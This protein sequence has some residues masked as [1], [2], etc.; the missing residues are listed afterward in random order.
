MFALELR[1]VLSVA[2]VACAL[3][4]CSSS[5][6]ASSNSP[7]SG[8]APASAGATSPIADA[9]LAA[10][11]QAR[12]SVMPAPST[13]ISALSWSNEIATSAQAWADGCM[14]KHSG[15]KYGENIFASAGANT[16]PQGVV[17]SWVAEVKD[18]DYA[19][20][21]CA[22]TCGHYT[23]VVWRKSSAL[24]CAVSNCSKNSPFSGFD[25]W[26]F[27]VCNYDPPGNFNGQK[28]Y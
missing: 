21:S 19:S 26:Q 9:I 2:V 25:Q 6:P 23:Q 7:N 12:A 4:A 27:W 14:F 3:S 11:N 20:N 5:D 28:P 13:P 22:A 15:G 24:G 1:C 10:H 8:G 17:D 16:T 18:Y